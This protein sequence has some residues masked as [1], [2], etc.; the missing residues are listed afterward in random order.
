MESGGCFPASFQ[1]A[2][3]CGRGFQPQCGWLIS[4]AP[5]EQ[6]NRKNSGE[7]FWRK[8]GGD[9]FYEGFTFSVN[10]PAKI[11]KQLFWTMIFASALATRSQA[12]LIGHAVTCFTNEP[13][14]KDVQE[15]M[16]LQTWSF[17]VHRSSLTNGISVYVEIK[18]EGRP[19][20]TVANEVLD[21]G[22]LDN[23]GVGEDIPVFVAMNPVGSMDGEDILSA[24]KLRFFLR[25]A[26]VQM[27]YVAENPFYKCKDGPATWSY[28]AAEESPTVYKLM[29]SN[30]GHNPS[31]PKTELTVRFHEF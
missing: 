18:I 9:N 8:I 19:T 26:G 31:G 27:A 15:A 24:K 22:I 14:G 21:Q 3:F 13:S 10:Q 20:Q 7:F 28:Y 4:D 2:R 11:M 23:L 1:D 30:T 29:E 12:E 16:G 5:S 17:K 25:D 6:R